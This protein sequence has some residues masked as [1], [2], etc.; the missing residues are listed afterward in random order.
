M[1]KSG[2]QE[3]QHDDISDNN[4]DANVNINI[5]RHIEK[6]G[7]VITVY[8]DISRYSGTFSNILP[9][10]VTLRDTKAY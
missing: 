6:L 2:R 7:I 4:I 10:P 5:S 3:F 8:S 1:D 9:C